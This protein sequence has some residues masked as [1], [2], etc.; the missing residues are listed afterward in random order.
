MTETEFIRACVKRAAK[1]S[2]TTYV[3]EWFRRDEKGTWEKEARELLREVPALVYS[4]DFI[5]MN[6]A[7]RLRFLANTAVL[8]NAAKK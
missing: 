7:L 4:L 8:N 5:E 1:E 2:T 6:I 3:R